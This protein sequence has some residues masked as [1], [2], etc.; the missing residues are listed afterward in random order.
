VVIKEFWDIIQCWL[1]KDGRQAHTGPRTAW[2]SQNSLRVWL[3]TAVQLFVGPWPLFQFLDLC[4]SSVGLL[5]REISPSQGRYLHKTKSTQNERTQTS[6]PLV[7]FEPTIPAFE[8]RENDSSCFRPCDHCGRHVYDCITELCRTQA[9]VIPSQVNPIY[10][11]KPGV[12]KYQLRGLNFAAVRPT[13][14]Q[15]TNCS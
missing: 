15:L 9:E 2:G 6:M 5:G 12:V 7:G 8:Q 13:T 4:T 3:S 10:K 14:V 11:E 1:L